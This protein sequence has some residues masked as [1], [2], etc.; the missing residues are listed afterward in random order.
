MM[1]VT[2]LVDMLPDAWSQA[3]ETGVP[4]WALGLA[5]TFGFLVLTYFTRGGCGCASDSERLR[6]GLHSPGLHRRAKQGAD[7]AVFGGVGTAVALTVH[8]ALESATLALTTSIVV[9]IALIVMSASDGLALAALLNIAKRRVA[10]WLLGSCLSSA[11]GIAIAAFSPLPGA[12]VPILLAV[13]MGVLS[14]TAIFGMKLAASKQQNGRL[15]ARQI[16][17][18][19][20]VAAG[21]GI[22]LVTARMQGTEGNERAFPTIRPGAATC[23]PGAPAR[24]ARCPAAQRII[25]EGR[26]GL[27]LPRS[28]GCFGASRH[29]YI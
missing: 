3:A 19:V 17:V 6:I 29:T 12:L 4:L 24:T 5:A 23:S 7:A 25:V 13:V 10:P 20:T 27:P 15:S 2:A 26:R 16:A 9:L 14:R 22:L 8:R 21:A 28:R 1:L 11:A 18:A